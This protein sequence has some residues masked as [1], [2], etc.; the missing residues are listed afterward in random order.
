MKCNKCGNDVLSDF[1]V[2]KDARGVPT[3][4]C[5]KCGACV[6]KMSAGE[7]VDVYEA[8]ISNLIVDDEPPAESNEP[9]VPKK[10][11]S[12]CR[13]CTERYVMVRGN[14]RVRAEYVPI[15]AVFCPICGRELE[16]SDLAY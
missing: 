5:G 10:K 2:K 14:P 15:E 16:A 3:A 9:P 8:K 12:P 13:Y 11:K 4:Y 1:T 7:I 6:K